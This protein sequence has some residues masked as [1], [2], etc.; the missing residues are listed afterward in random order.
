MYVPAGNDLR[1]LLLFLQRGSAR[2][3]SVLEFVDGLIRERT[4]EKRHELSRL[5]IWAWAVTNAHPKNTNDVSAIGN[6]NDVSSPLGI[7]RSPR[8]FKNSRNFYKLLGFLLDCSC[9]GIFYFLYK[10]SIVCLIN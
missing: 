5:R 4:L 8:D 6:I 3:L 7:E 2:T 10:N 1:L 9:D